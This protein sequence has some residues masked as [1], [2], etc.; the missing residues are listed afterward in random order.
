MGGYQCGICTR[1]FIMSLMRCS[2]PTRTD[3]DEIA[4]ALSANIC[5][6]SDIHRSSIPQSRRRR[7]ARE[8]TITM[9]GVGTG[10]D[11][12]RAR[13]SVAGE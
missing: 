10:G 2:R 13:R 3:N 11:G 12:G 8:Q 4:E 7:N 5:R 1:G 9:S 6:C